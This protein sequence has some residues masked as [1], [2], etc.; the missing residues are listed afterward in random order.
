MQ[1]E[2]EK[3]SLF[4]PLTSTPTWL[5]FSTYGWVKDLPRITVLTSHLFSHGSSPVLLHSLR[6][7]T[8]TVTLTSS[9]SLA[10]I[11]QL[12]PHSLQSSLEIS[13]HRRTFHTSWLCTSSPCVGGSGQG[14]AFGFHTFL[15]LLQH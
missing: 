14:S 4:L 9:D 11:L 8:T 15:Q 6:G 13:C 1:A 7:L 3:C 10:T 5:V 12:S 2:Q